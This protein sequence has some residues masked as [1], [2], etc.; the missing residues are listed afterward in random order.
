MNDR[1]DKPYP[2]AR[3]YLRHF[4][5]LKEVAEPAT[6]NDFRRLSDGLCQTVRN[7]TG[8]KYPVQHWDMILIHM[9]HERLDG[10]SASAWNLRR[11]NNNAPTVAEMVTFLDERNDAANEKERQ[12]RTPI[13]V[14]VQKEHASRPQSRNRNESSSSRG[15]NRE[16][17]HSFASAPVTKNVYPCTVCNAKDYKIFVCP[18]FK[19]LTHAGRLRVVEK[20]GIC[21]LCLKKGHSLKDCYDLTRCGDTRCED[22]KHNSMLCPYKVPSQVA[23]PAMESNRNAGPANDRRS[24]SKRRNGSAGRSD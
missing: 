2:L 17:T 22:K 24:G 12:R 18:E 15:S 14:V 7:L 11:G 23:M 4:F 10:P 3:A 9:I 5:S 8:V 1:Y 19:P 13:S 20:K 21:R 16:G 6:A